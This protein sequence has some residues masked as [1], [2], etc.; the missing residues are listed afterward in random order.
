MTGHALLKF[1]E[2]PPSKYPYLKEKTGMPIAAFINFS[3]IQNV[4]PIWF[5]NI[6]FEVS[7]FLILDWRSSIYN[8][9]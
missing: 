9:D 4:R 5:Y 6:Q 8:H 7:F 3:M 1:V 2:W